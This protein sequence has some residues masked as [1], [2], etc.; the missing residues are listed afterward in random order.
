MPCPFRQSYSLKLR[1]NVRFLCV[2]TIAMLWSL[3]GF[4]SLSLVMHLTDSTVVVCSLAKEPKMTFDDK[5]LTLSSIEGTVGQWDFAGVESWNIADVE[6]VD[7]VNQV[8]VDKARICIGEGIITVA[9]TDA[10]QIAVYDAN[11]RSVTSMPNNAGDIISFS[12][13][14]LAKGTYLL[15]VGN[16]SIKFLVQ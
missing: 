16:S 6:D 15:K 2:L 10:E 7:A 12:I 8:N 1:M 11:G 9:G 13:N 4:A 5:T 3:P 14:G